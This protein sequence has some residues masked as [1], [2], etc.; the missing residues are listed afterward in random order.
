M[1]TAEQKERRVGQGETLQSPGLG[2]PSRQLTLS[3]GAEES[4][5]CSSSPVAHNSVFGLI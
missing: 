2:G 5:L 4:E 3:L 1:E